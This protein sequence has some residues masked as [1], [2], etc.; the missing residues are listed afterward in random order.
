MGERVQHALP[1]LPRARLDQRGGDLHL[2]V[3]HGRV[4]RG[5]AEVGL[6]AALLGLAQA[7][8]DVLAQLLQRVE[9]GVDREVVVDR[10]ELLAL[11]LLDGHLEGR[12]AAGE[13]RAGVVGGEGQRERAPLSRAGPHER[14][15]E[16]LDQLPDPSSTSWS[17][18]SP[19]AKGSRS[20][21]S[22]TR[23]PS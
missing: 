13:L 22:P 11:D 5:L 15:L 12:R 1:H 8:A 3:L 16:A 20:P 7:P 4:E 23:A 17:R 6:D 10:R 2:G 19:P 21:A 9:A 14:V 18:P